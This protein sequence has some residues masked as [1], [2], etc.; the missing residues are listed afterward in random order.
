MEEN[1]NNEQ[2]GAGQ[3]IIINQEKKESNGIGTAGFIISIIALFVGW[4]PFIGWLVWLTGAILSLIG[5]F[6][7]P[8]GL[9]IAGLIISFIGVILLIFVL[10]GI[11]LAAMSVQ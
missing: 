9:S 10:A 5:V 6:K 1:N 7:K 2:N 4:V 3:T 11:G 8:K